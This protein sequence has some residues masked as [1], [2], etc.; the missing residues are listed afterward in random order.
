LFIDVTHA[1]FLENESHL[2]IV[3]DALSK[4]YSD[5]QHFLTLS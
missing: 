3:L 1:D 4:D 2:N 5:G